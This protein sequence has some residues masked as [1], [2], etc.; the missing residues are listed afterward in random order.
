MEK[1]YNIP[2]EKFA[3]VHDGERISDKKFD[4]VNEK[5]FKFDDKRYLE[6]AIDN[7]NS[8]IEKNP[9]LLFEVN[10][11][12]ISRKYRTSPYPDLNLLK[13]LG[14]RDAK[15]IINSDTHS[16]DTIDFEF[17]KA[18]EHCINCGVKTVYILRKNGIEQ[19]KL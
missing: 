2:K 18:I 17:D 14:E 8:I 9:E 16:A 19:I 12:A 6:I 5:Y 10:T 7:L 11:G 1:K 4:E 15:I 3:F 13:H